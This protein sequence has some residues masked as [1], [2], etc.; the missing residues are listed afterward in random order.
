M[1][2][3]RAFD[4][5]C[6]I[7]LIFACGSFDAQGGD[8][9]KATLDLIRKRL[10]DIS[11]PYHVDYETDGLWG[12]DYMRTLGRSKC[13]LNLSRQREGPI[14]LA[15]PE[16]LYIYSSDR[17]S[18]LTGNGVLTFT[19]EQNHFDQLFTEDEMVFFKS[20]E[21]LVEKIA[22][23]LKNDDGRRR[24][25]KNGWKKTHRELNERLAAQYI[26][27]VLFREELSHPYI[28]PTEMVI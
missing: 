24:I 25:A 9:R 11:F 13:G 27:D 20:N 2:A 26:V 21:D 23:Y 4:A 5:D 17:V 7:D 15:K 3:G 14:N 22:H 6:D 28:W 10:P 12:A 18:Q 8:P 16:D 1:E 19:H